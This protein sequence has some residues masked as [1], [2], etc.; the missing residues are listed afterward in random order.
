MRDDIWSDDIIKWVDVVGPTRDE[1]EEVA[2]EFG[3]PPTAVE[4][5]LD[6]EHLPKVERYGDATFLI[7]RSRDPD[8]P[9]DADSPIELTRKLS[10]F[11]RGPLLLTVHRTRLPGIDAMKAR[12]MSES[13]DEIGGFAGVL[14][15]LIEAVLGSYDMPLDRSEATL[16]S[17]EEGIFDDDLPAPTMREMHHLKRRIALTRRLLW[18]MNTVLNKLVP[19]GERA[20]PIFQDMRES[21]EAYLFWVEQ[22]FDQVNQLLQLHLAMAA[23]RT[24]DVMRVLTVFSAFFLPL[25]FIVGVYGMNFH[26]MPELDWKYGYIG[27]LI[28]MA[29]MSIA[30]FAWFR[31]RGWL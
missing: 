14:A 20:E 23:N 11:I 1:M 7:L 17:F 31:R 16:D 29:A 25:T 12:L 9:E 18:Q 21:S 8:A 19:P 6:P 2:T 13:L 3:I 24:N 22:M 10:I 4:D 26:R 5:C 28:L 15:G 27:V 30:I